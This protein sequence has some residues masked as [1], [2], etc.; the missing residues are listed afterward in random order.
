MDLTRPIGHIQATGWTAAAVGNTATTSCGAPS[1]TRKSSAMPPCSLAHCRSFVAVAG[2]LA[3]RSLDRDRVAA[4]AIRVTEL[5]LFCIGSERYAREDHTYGAASL[6]RR[7]LA[8][9]GGEAVFDYTAKEGKRR[10]VRIANPPGVHTLRS[11][12]ALPAT[13]PQL[14]V[15]QT[16]QGCRH[17]TTGELVTYLH[18]HAGSCST[19][20][21]RRKRSQGDA[22]RADQGVPQWRAQPT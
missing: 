13:P 11:L 20:T 10:T 7:H 1:A 22:G 4:C 18:R 5:G 14:V 17:L 8:F 21:P 2:H 19:I 9:R 16:G 6:E 12:H 15:Y 3:R